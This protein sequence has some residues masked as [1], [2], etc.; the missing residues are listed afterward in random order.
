M[1][2]RILSLIS[3]GA[4][5][6]LS[7][8]SRKAEDP[9]ILHR[10]HQ[11][12]VINVDSGDEKM[13]AAIT[14]ARQTTASYLQILVSPKPNQTGFSVKRPYATAEGSDTDQEH[15]WISNLSYDGKLLH[16]TVG[17]EPANIPHL[18]FGEPV[19]FSP[20][21][22]SD[23][24]YLEDGKIVGGYT[25][26]VLRNQMPDKERAEFDKQLQFKP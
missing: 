14:Q 23:W 2:F 11:P 26:R 3:L 15:I 25:I 10:D 7:S 20:S 1:N 8:C 21:E 6:L 9:K 24:M 13:N 16:G 19:S 22:L 4:S 5:I 17:D 18:K 12:D